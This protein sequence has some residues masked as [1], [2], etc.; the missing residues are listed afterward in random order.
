MSTKQYV[1]WFLAGGI[2]SLLLLY[3]QTAWSFTGKSTIQGQVLNEK[4]IHGAVAAYGIERSGYLSKTPLA[5]S[6]TDSEGHFE[7]KI[8]A[9]YAG[10]LQ[11]T[12][13][14][15]PERLTLSTCTARKFCGAFKQTDNANSTDN[16]FDP[17][18]KNNNNLIDFGEL[19]VVN[20]NY[21]ISAT[22]PHIESNQQINVYI[23]PLTDIAS[24]ISDSSG[25]KNARLI[26]Y[27]NRW[28]A[29]Q[30]QLTFSILKTQ[31]IDIA[32]MAYVPRSI[33]EHYSKQLRYALLAAAFTNY[34]MT[35]YKGDTQ[36]ARLECGWSFSIAFLK[37]ALTTKTKP[38]S[39]PVCYMN[40]V[41]AAA[42][43]G[44]ELPNL[45]NDIA[46][47]SLRYASPNIAESFM[48]QASSLRTPTVWD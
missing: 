43:L 38:D 8:P 14:N 12:V 40:I 18:D 24:Q 29:Q 37:K 32:G 36:S 7:I 10:P 4:I 47:R 22:I 34:G 6:E 31:P 15:H 13:Y 3:A 44:D 2:A 25:R 1:R 26:A 9:H 45:V 42:V 48:K 17:K 21:A 41:K 39:V 11:L 30:F 16:R 46:A 28:V 33:S 35:H 5:R 23:T 27:A 20:K 19:F